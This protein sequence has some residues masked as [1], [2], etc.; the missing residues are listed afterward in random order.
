MSLYNGPPRPGEQALCLPT[1]SKHS[2]LLSLDSEAQPT[3]VLQGD[4]KSLHH[5]DV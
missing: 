4:A 3:L 5:N 1:K 2:L